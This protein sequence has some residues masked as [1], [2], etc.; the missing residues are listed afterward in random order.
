[1]ATKTQSRGEQRLAQL[2]DSEREIVRSL[3]RLNT[4]VREL[5]DTVNVI[6]WII[7]AFACLF[8]LGVIVW[9]A[10]LAQSQ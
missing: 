1:V 5:S 8:V 9:I 3:D 4:T 7:V 10:S 2:S 6:R